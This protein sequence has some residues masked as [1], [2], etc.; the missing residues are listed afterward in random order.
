M[1]NLSVLDMHITEQL[2]TA[3]SSPVSQ[4]YIFLYITICFWPNAFWGEAAAWTLFWKVT[5]KFVSEGNEQGGV[6]GDLQRSGLSHWLSTAE[7]KRLCG[8]GKGD[9]VDL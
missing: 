8:L 7:A 2:E 1:T 3:D 9:I 6:G 4:K 5:N